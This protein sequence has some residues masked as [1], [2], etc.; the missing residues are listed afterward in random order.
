MRPSQKGWI[1]SYL[2]YL[3]NQEEDQSFYKSVFDG[4]ASLEHDKKLYKLVQPTGLMYGHPLR[5][6]RNYNISLANWNE[7]EKMKFILL[8]GM[9]NDAL[10][11]N[12]NEINNKSDFNDCIHNTMKSISAFYKENI[13]LQNDYFSF[14]KNPK[15]EAEHVELILNRRLDVRTSWTGNFWASF[16]QNSL[17]FLDVYFFDQWIQ[18]RED[19]H[20][21]NN[22]SGQQE[23]L[24]LNIL[25][26][27]AAAARSNHVIEDEEKALFKFFLQSAHLGKENEKIA[28]NYLKTDICLEDIKFDKN[29]PWIIRKYILELA[30]LTVWADKK[31]EEI[32]KEFVRQ[33]A[34]KL[35]F[36]K[37]E[38]ES[39][40]L[41]IE[42]FVISNWE[43][44][45]F[46][47]KRHNLLII[48]ERFSQRIAKVVTKN[49]KAI[50]QEIRESKELM[51]LLVK[52]TK[53][54]LSDK[55]K[56]IV[57]AQL[58]DVL[59]TLPT[60]VIIALPGTF[61]T[62]P[63]LLNILPKSAFPSAFSEI[64]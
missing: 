41:A 18:N 48:K 11:I 39:S 22:F 33:L 47:Q 56:S 20:G 15:S 49:K 62:L 9:I 28:I 63:V 10:I 36:S 26:I 37:D 40:L 32:E 2:K 38:F 24:R 13:E 50:V 57:K 1:N 55:E 17:L 7:H 23:N 60:F 59:K 12:S 51:N 3:L 43:Q 46:L 31:V 21:S 16:F 53:E 58:I 44:V 64:D 42:S 25:Q 61:I 30:I 34:K 45:H 4:P 35:G 54:D 14:R 6:P 29:D 5:P 8:D 52:M 27:I 19:V